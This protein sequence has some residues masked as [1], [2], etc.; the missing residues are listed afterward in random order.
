VEH[1][2]NRR[3][4]RSGG[5]VVS[6]VLA[7]MGALDLFAA[8]ILFPTPLHLT[9][10]IEDSLG[11]TDPALVNVALWCRRDPRHGA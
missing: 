7:A 11:A 9:R 4:G 3:A 2:S 5:L 8:E 6:I 1:A 10:R